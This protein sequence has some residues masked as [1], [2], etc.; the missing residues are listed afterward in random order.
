MMI[1][2]KLMVRLVPNY[3][4]DRLDDDE[5]LAVFRSVLDEFEEY[6]KVV[7]KMPE[8]LYAQILGF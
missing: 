6:V 1:A 8:E 5:Q 3:S 2:M 4:K 7:P